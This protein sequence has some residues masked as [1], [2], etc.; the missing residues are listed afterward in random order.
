[1]HTRNI[2]KNSDEIWWLKNHSVR[3]FNKLLPKAKLPGSGY[4]QSSVNI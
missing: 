4:L 3:L 2:G 1:M